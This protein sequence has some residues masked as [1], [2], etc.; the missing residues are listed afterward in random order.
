MDRFIASS[1][2]NLENRERER[3]DETFWEFI[4]KK[5]EQWSKINF[6]FMSE[7]WKKEN[8]IFDISSQSINYNWKNYKMELPKW[9]EL[10]EI[11]FLNNEVNVKWMAWWFTWEWTISYS[12]LIKSL[13]QLFK[14]WNTIIA[15]ESW[16]INIFAV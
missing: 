1:Q 7:S 16:N 12:Q 9:A 5:F 14:N 4:W 2:Q 3:I 15:S 11:S 13:D 8:C 10:K 6:L